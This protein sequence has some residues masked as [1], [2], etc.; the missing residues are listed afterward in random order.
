MQKRTVQTKSSQVM[1]SWAQVKERKKMHMYFG[2]D[3]DFKGRKKCSL[4]LP[5]QFYPG[6]TCASSKS[7]SRRQ[8]VKGLKEIETNV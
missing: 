4:T 6:H 1:P 3:E 7:E 8:H 2:R 5:R